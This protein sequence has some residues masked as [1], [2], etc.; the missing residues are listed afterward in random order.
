M[1]R[2]LTLA[3]IAAT[4]RGLGDEDLVALARP[5]LSA[6][7]RRPLTRPR[8][9]SCSRRFAGRL[10][11]LLRERD[12]FRAALLEV[13]NPRPYTVDLGELGPLDDALV[14]RDPGPD[15]RGR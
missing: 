3:D 11:S 2:A 5:A 13:E 1:S 6:L 9:C 12:A 7:L 10:R 15:P 8:R 4:I 14:L